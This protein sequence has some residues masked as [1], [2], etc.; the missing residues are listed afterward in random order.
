[1]CSLPVI[2]YSLLLLLTPLPPALIFFVLP[3]SNKVFTPPSTHP[4]PTDT[5]FF[6]C[7]LPVIKY[8]LLLPLTPLPPHLFFFVCVLPPSNKVVTPL[9]T[10]PPPNHRQW[11]P[12]VFEHYLPLP[13]TGSENLRRPCRCQVS[14][15]HYRQG[16]SQKALHC[17]GLGSDQLEGFLR[18]PLPMAKSWGPVG[19]LFRGSFRGAP[20][21]NKSLDLP[22]K[23]SL[24]AV[25]ST[26]KIS[27]ALYS[28]L[29]TYSQA[30]SCNKTLH[31]EKAS[32]F[33][34]RW[35]SLHYRVFSKWTFRTKVE[36][37]LKVTSPQV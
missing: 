26:I 12:Q 8:S 11:G 30:R 10:H 25:K 15:L 3:P 2:K 29:C 23:F 27:T 7:S 20:P 33:I 32:D 22:W 13:P 34:S 19:A 4:P 35:S 16:P 36:L 18:G 24:Q 31:D 1:M 5:Y 28:D 9:S 14:R 17:Q 21:V 6:L 37:D